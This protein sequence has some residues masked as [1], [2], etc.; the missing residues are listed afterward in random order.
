MMDVEVCVRDSER[1]VLAAAVSEKAWYSWVSQRL[2]S[3]EE[4]DM[5]V[6]G[7]VTPDELIPLETE[8]G[9]MEPGRGEEWRERVVVGH[10]VSYDRARTKEQYLMKVCTF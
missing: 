1:P 10:H 5:N 3:V 8:E 2:L 9:R 7:R 4:C 6:Q